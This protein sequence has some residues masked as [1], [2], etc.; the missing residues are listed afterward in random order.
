MK[1][2]L[3]VGDAQRSVHEITTSRDTR[4]KLHR[5]N[6]YSNTALLERLGCEI[7]H[8]STKGTDMKIRNR[9]RTP[10]RHGKILLMTAILLPALM[11]FMALGVDLG[12]IAASKAQ[13]QTVADAAS[14]AGAMKL[15][16][17]NRVRG[18]G[19]TNQSSSVL[20][21]TSASVA[22][23]RSVGQANLVLNSAPVIHDNSSN[24]ADGDVVVG[25]FNPT[26]HVWAAPPLSSPALSNAVLVNASR[27]SARG[28]SVPGFFSRVWTYAGTDVKAQSIAVAQNY[29]ING[30]KA[31]STQNAPMIPITLDYSTYQAMMN[32][33]T[34]DNYSYD[35]ATNTVSNGPDNIYESHLYPNDTGSPGSWGTLVIGTPN[36]GTSDLVSQI[37]YGI[38]PQQI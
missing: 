30:F 2:K 1:S 13:L 28:S 3:R 33:T 25:Y 10:A 18:V 24:A 38:T 6:G 21:E 31:G 26:T 14:L 22:M 17:E 15:A 12:I 11:A 8:E 32:R 27:T 36:N 29:P 35:S 4:D 7:I 20:P 34:T 9:F 5:V 19:T 16:D 23:A 37:L